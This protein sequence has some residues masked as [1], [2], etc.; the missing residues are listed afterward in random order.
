[1]IFAR[2]LRIAAVAAPA[3]AAALFVTSLAT[4]QEQ[5]PRP[6]ATPPASATQPARTGRG[7]GPRGPM[8]VSPD[9]KADRRVTFRVIAPKAEAVRL[10]TSDLPGNQGE[11]RVL[12]KGENGVWELTLG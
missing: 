6:A 8:V 4:A 7:G 12:T 11:Q 10:Q 3:V 9:V 2:T 5:Q 1:M